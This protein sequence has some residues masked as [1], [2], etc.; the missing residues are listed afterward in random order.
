MKQNIIY[1]HIPLDQEWKL[2]ILRD[3]L[4]VKEDNFNDNEI[5]TMINFYVPTRNYIFILYFI[6]VFVLSNSTILPLCTKSYYIILDYLQKQ[7]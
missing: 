3:L 7:E 6:L 4:K 1:N 5:A 2:P